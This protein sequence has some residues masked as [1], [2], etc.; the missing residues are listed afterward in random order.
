MHH[1]TGGDGSGW[2][3]SLILEGSRGR[4]LV[5]V[6][7]GCSHRV[8]ETQQPLPADVCRPAR[9]AFPAWGG[10]VFADSRSEGWREESAFSVRPRVLLS[11]CY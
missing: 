9:P 8:L 7:P 2:A 10:R 11:H 1:L 3:P 4:V 5:W 6:P